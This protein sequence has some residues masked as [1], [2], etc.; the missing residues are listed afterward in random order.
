MSVFS[1]LQFQSPCQIGRM[2]NKILQVAALLASATFNSVFAVDIYEAI[3]QGD[4]KAAQ[5]LLDKGANVNE[6]RDQGFTPLHAALFANETEIAKL[7]LAKGAKNS[8]DTDGITPLHIAASFGQ[9]TIMEL[10]LKNGANINVKDNDG[11]TPLHNACE[12][13][14]I[15]A[16]RL[17]LQKKANVNLKDDE[18]RTPLALVKSFIDS[19]N[20]GDTNFL[21]II[22]LL[23]ANGG[24]E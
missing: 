9:I 20:A 17:L 24:K 3:E 14:N 19:E 1:S 15:D 16:V 12:S 5:A 23:K 21:Q 2:K 10:L 22:D 4:V 18:G 11:F 6:L 8:P 13:G 7:L